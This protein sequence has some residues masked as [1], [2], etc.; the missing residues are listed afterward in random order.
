[1]H[2]VTCSPMARFVLTALRSACMCL[3]QLGGANGVGRVDL[4]ESRFVG[5]KSRG[6][7]RAIVSVII[8][9]ISP[10]VS[11]HLQ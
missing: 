4:V 5:M 8:S 7:R 6:G 10:S 11:R 2:D 9:I 3:L 1:M